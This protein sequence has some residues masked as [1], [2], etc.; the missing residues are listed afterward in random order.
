MRK[1]EWNPFKATQ[2]MGAKKDQV[3]NCPEN[4]LKTEVRSEECLNI[5]QSVTA[6]V[7]WELNSSSGD[8]SRGNKL[9]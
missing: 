3:K 9:S 1:H 2:E 4:G 5:S 7:L 6:P 8:L